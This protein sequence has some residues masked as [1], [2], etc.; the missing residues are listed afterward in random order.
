MKTSTFVG[1]LVFWIA[2]GIPCGAC[3]WWARTA[4]SAAVADA[5]EASSWLLA[6][7]IAALPFALYAVGAVVG[8]IV[9]KVGGLRVNQF[10]KSNAFI[11]ASLVLALMI[12]S[13]APVVA[14]GADSGFSAP[15]LLISYAG[16]FV[17][18]LFPVMGVLY[19]I[20]IAPAK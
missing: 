14:L 6:G 13:V 4:D 2:V 7:A 20:G 17:P 3:A 18:L 11:V 8:L 5:V 15:T 1:N 16:A 9:I 10:L 19:A 12:A